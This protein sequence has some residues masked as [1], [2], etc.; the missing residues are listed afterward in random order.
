[1]QRLQAQETRRGLLL[2]RQPLLRALLA[3]AAPWLGPRI[4][5]H[6]MTSQLPLRL[7][8]D[9]L[10]D[11][12]RSP[13]A[14]M[15]RSIAAPPA[16]ALALLLGAGLPASLAKPVPPLQDPPSTD[17]LRGIQLSAQI[18]ARDNTEATCA[19]TRS[20]ADPLLD[21]GTVS[22]SCKDSAYELIQRAK[23]GDGSSYTRRDRIE[24]SANDLVRLCRPKTRPVG[25]GSSGNGANPGKSTTPFSLR[26]EPQP[27][28]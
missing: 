18:C 27:G 22:A 16:L 1:M 6:W 4:R 10:S 8:L 2:R 28:P 13:G 7:G 11:D 12:G 3:T 24:A 21:H 20:L 15:V 25:D 14:P 26:G 17:S 9:D 5:H 23:V 19:R